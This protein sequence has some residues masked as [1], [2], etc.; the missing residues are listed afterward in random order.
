VG[1]LAG[2]S[3]ISQG[4]RPVLLRQVEPA[5]MRASRGRWPAR[6]LCAGRPTGLEG[7]LRYGTNAVCREHSD[8]DDAGSKDD[9]AAP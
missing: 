2:C 1:W 6:V 9:A 3:P 8:V 4:R 5:A 7:V